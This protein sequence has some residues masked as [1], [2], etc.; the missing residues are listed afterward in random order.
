V[1][2]AEHDGGGPVAEVRVH[3]IGN[4]GPWSALGSPRPRDEPNP[5]VDVYDPPSVEGLV[6]LVNWSRTSR[7]SAGFVW[8]L[9]LPFTLVNVAGHMR[10]AGPCRWPHR[11]HCACT[12]VVGVLVT[13]SVCVWVIV[14]AE[15]ILKHLGSI[16][17]EVFPDGTDSDEALPVTVWEALAWTSL[18]RWVALVLGAGFALL[19]VGRHLLRRGVS[20]TSWGLVALHAGAFAAVGGSA[21]YWRPVTLQ[22]PEGA[23]EW[24]VVRLAGERFVDPVIATAAVTGGLALLAAGVLLATHGVVRRP[25]PGP[26]LPGAALLLSAAVVL[27]HAVLS[28]ARVS[29]DWLGDYVVGLSGILAER[30]AQP[31]VGLRT[32]LPYMDRAEGVF[33]ID[34]VV[35]GALVFALASIAGLGLTLVWKRGSSELTGSRLHKV[36]QRLPTI[37]APAVAVTLVLFT[38]GI[39]YLMMRIAQPGG[40]ALAPGLRL[41]IVTLVQAAALLLVLLVAGRL[42][43]LSDVLQ[44]F[45]DVAGF[46]RVVYHPLAGASYRPAVLEGIRK[47][48]ADTGAQRVIVVGHSQGSVLAVSVVA[49]LFE[50]S[51]GPELGVEYRLVTCGSPL[52]AL[53]GAFF[54]A[55]FD[56]RLPAEIPWTNCWRATDAIA[57]PIQATPNNVELPDPRPPAKRPLGH[58]DYW[59]DPGLVGAVKACRTVEV[60]RDSSVGQPEVARPGLEPETP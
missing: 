43:N 20:S 7:L 39:A 38:A 4:H 21:A 26:A 17:T 19:V 32:L 54:P 42:Q 46:W 3:G 57:S 23:P 45:A 6:R 8:F 49:R 18:F 5:R 56:G 22:A 36:V 34:V 40:T 10:P 33:R 29:L 13:V 1:T 35:L 16:N 47:A 15:T 12:H 9:A 60:P 28:A 27:T 53:Y 55:E 31:S 59:T 11:V 14:L 44:R 25:A 30:G 51:D 41:A 48:I 52:D 24:L 58:D 2:G 50:A 37:L